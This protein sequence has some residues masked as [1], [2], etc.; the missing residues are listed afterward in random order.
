MLPES[1]YIQSCLMIDCDVIF[2]TYVV[3]SCNAVT[4]IYS[5]SHN[6]MSNPLLRE[7]YLYKLHYCTCKLHTI[8]YHMCQR[9]KAYCG[10]KFSGLTKRK[11][12]VNS[13]SQDTS[14][15]RNVK[16]F[17]HAGN[18]CRQYGGTELLW[19]PWCMEYWINNCGI[20]WMLLRYI[21]DLSRQQL[22][23]SSASKFCM[24]FVL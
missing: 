14:S 10:E 17:T 16:F 9:W 2:F 19:W 24:K 7:A 23:H 18:I 12:K 1:S 15:N 11:K 13:I 4:G 6:I 3:F 5:P 22:K 20:P 8:S 21:I